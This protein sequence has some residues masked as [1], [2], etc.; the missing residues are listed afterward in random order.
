MRSGKVYV[1]CAPLPDLAFPPY[2][3]CPSWHR[4]SCCI[5]PI[6]PYK[7][8]N[9]VISGARETEFFPSGHDKPA[10]KC[11]PNG[12][13]PFFQRKNSVSVPH[14]HERLSFPSGHDKPARKC[15][16]N[17]SILPFRRKTQ[18]LS[19]P[20]Q[21]TAPKCAP[22]G[23]T[24]SFQKNNSASFL[25]TH[26]RPSFS[27]PGKRTALKMLSCWLTPYPFREKTR[28]LSCIVEAGLCLSRNAT[29]RK[30]ASQIA[31]SGSGR[32]AP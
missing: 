27:P 18:S 13:P 28:S 16:P 8:K 15:T 2:G 23:K 14:T 12:S 26:E 20:G 29:P 30:K 4:A 24:L 10:R 5:N 1:R 11:T 3:P 31:C 9:Q 32:S 21:R 22:V 6:H 17:G 25:P 19:P 7:R